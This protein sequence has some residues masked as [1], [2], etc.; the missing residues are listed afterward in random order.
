[1]HVGRK[2]VQRIQLVS[3]GLGIGALIGVL[4]APKAGRETREELM[5]SAREGTEYSEAARAGMPPTRSATWW[6]GKT[7]VTEYVERGKEYVERG[8]AQWDEF[9]N[10][11]RQFVTDQGE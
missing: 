3:C 5:S 10:Q 6:T 2:T 1:M 11:G 4:Y 8:R 7:Q 9:V